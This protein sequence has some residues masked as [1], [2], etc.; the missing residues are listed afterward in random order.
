MSFTLIFFL[1]LVIS[2]YWIWTQVVPERQKEMRLRP[3][4]ALGV[5]EK[6]NQQRREMGLPLLEVDETLTTVAENKAAHQL[7][8][9]ISDEGWDYP[10]AYQGMFGQSLLMEALVEA[11]STAVAERLMHQRDIFDGEWI[12]CG[13]GIAGD[14]DQV[15]AALVLCR[16]AWE[17]VAETA[18]SWPLTEHLRKA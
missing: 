11:P 17:P 13:L 6:L 12:R 9:G 15:V 16:Q 5:L 7:A 18:P 14:R 4:L 10:S 3:T 1:L 8:T 2:V